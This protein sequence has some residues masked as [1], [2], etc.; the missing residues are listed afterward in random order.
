[1]AVGGVKIDLN[2]EELRGFATKLREFL[3]P[4]VAAKIIGAAV[5]KA[6]VPM[7]QRLKDITPV[8]PTGN[9]KL[10][11]SSK[12]VEYK[13]SGV[14]VGIVGYRRAGN[15]KS[16][17]AAGGEVRIGPDRAF[18]Q[19]WLEN[20]TK[21][22]TITKFSNKRYERRSPTVPF[23]RRRRAGKNKNVI[24]EIVRGKGVVHSV[25]GQNAYIASSLV[26][27]GPFKF[28]RTQR[29]AVATDPPYPRAFF[30][31][32]REPIVIPPMPAGGKSGQP[33]VQTAFN[34]TQG[35]I[36]AILQRELGMSLAE[37]WSTLRVRDSGT[38]EG[39]D[40]L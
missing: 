39:T 26:R 34:L 2:T 10:A 24:E 20:G 32:S 7:R 14:A 6:I 40:T 9:M 36:A 38:F 30:K 23:L 35:E 13:Q 27:L 31:K 15:A 19:W 18:H 12:V 5:K 37:A 8:G 33:P 21:A 17:S 25:S 3:P 1:M 22:R 4:Q 28:D 29:P 16:E 11:V